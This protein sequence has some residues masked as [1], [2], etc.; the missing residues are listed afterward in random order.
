MTVVCNYIN[1]CFPG[2][3]S[4]HPYPRSASIA[5]IHG[6]AGKGPTHKSDPLL[7]AW[8]QIAISLLEF[9]PQTQEP[10]HADPL[11]PLTGDTAEKLTALK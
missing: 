6:E 5:L 9:N 10:V 2:G 4:A 8:P 3:D 11:C 1:T 7:H